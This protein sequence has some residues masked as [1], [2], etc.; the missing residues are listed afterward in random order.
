ME[1][2][3]HG[4]VSQQSNYF[5]IEYDYEGNKTEMTNT[6]SC[7]EYYDDLVFTGRAE[8]VEFQIG[9]NWEVTIAGPGSAD[10]EMSYKVNAGGWNLV[11]NKS[12]SDSGTYYITDIDYNDAIYIRLKT[13]IGGVGD[14]CQI[15]T[16]LIN[17]TI[18]KGTGTVIANGT[19]D[20]DLSVSL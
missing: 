10:A 7:K 15:E 5:E 20:W 17:G 14:S 13:E 3:T 19:V 11:V 12:A 6:D 1:I 4:I 18:T 8:P 2:L 9:I 16:E